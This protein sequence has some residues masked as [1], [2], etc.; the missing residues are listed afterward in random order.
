MKRWLLILLLCAAH[1]HAGETE[2]VFNSVRDSVVTLTVYDERKE[3]DGAGSGV[4]VAPG[5]VITNCHVVQE[6]VAIQVRAG[7]KVWSATVALADSARDLC[8]LDV[9]GLTAPAA[10]IRS[11]REVQIGEPIYAVGNPLGFELA[12]SAGLVSSIGP[13][14]GELRLFSSAPISP[15]SSGGGLFDSKGRLIGITTGF[16]PGAQNLNLAVPADWI[17][18]LPARGV[19]KVAVPASTPD[20]DWPG[21]SETHRIAGEW[22]KLAAWSRRWLEAYPKSAEAGSYL[23]FA[24]LKLNQA[25]EGK[26]VLLAALQNDPLHAVSQGY[27]AETRFFLGEKQAA[28]ADM[29][30]AI[31]LSPAVGYFYLV[32]ALWQ[33]ASGDIPGAFDSIQTALKLDPGNEFSWDVL[34]N[35]HQRQQHFAE[36]AQASRSALR[37]KPNFPQASANLALSLAALGEASAARQTLMATT[38]TGDIVDAAAWL[39]VGVTEEKQGHFAEAE[40]AYRKSLE[41]SPTFADAWNSLG[42]YLIRVSR[43][44]EAEEALRQAVKHKPNFA[45]AWVT[46]GDVALQRGDKAGAKEAFEKATVAD[47]KYAGGWFGLGVVRSQLGDFTSAVSP[48][49]QAIRLDPSRSA[50]WAYLGEMQFRS[51]QRDAAYKS[52]QQAEKL[53]SKNETALS[54]LTMYYG[55][56]G[57]PGKSLEYAQR[58]L[59]V[60]SA[61]AHHWNGKGYALIKLRRYPEAIPALE[62]ATRLQPDLI[63]AWINLGEAYLRSKQLGKAIA[64]LEQALKLAPKATDAQ[65]FISQAYAGSGQNDKAKEQLSRLVLQ[66]P[67]FAHAWGLLTVVNL[68]Q[69]NQ[70]DA[71]AAYAKLKL[72]NSTMARELSLAFRKQNPMSTIQLPN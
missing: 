18:E 34:A 6:A 65:L 15:G 61:S 49:E 44:T 39:G 30:N 8:Q 19:P 52:L 56:S 36:A 66:A 51:G 4:V 46:L 48:L 42:H 41:I 37:L 55:M 47:P 12:V 50:G 32:R 14:K 58:A 26:Q 63:A 31:V 13:H 69:G 40:R 17:A 38:P 53:D 3:V 29:Q 62:T 9:P 72:I 1:A 59:A 43:N 60:N 64:T 35:L 24:L 7:E 27:L 67:N 22:A 25:E 20:P 33:R 21:Q 70:P 5:R 16:Y 28:Q 10:K 68:S 57:D 2:T 45:P 54:A 71:L 11:Y 23:G